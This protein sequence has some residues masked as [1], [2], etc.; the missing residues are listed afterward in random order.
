MAEKYQ[1][2]GA[3]PPLPPGGEVGVGIGPPDDELELLDEL[4]E[5]E[6]DDELELLD[7]LEEDELEE[8]ELDDVGTYSSAPMS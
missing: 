1:Q 5:D 6:L 7:E 3:P 2:L 8:D 4:E